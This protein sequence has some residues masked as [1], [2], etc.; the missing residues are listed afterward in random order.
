M[1]LVAWYPLNGHLKDISTSNANI[2][3]KVSTTWVDGKMR[4]MLSDKSKYFK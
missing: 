1:S 3:P 4:K 2:S